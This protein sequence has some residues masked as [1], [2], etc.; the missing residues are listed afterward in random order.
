[1]FGLCQHT[2]IC[3]DIIDVRSGNCDATELLSRDIDEDGVV[4]SVQCDSINSSY[5]VDFDRYVVNKALAYCSEYVTKAKFTRRIHVNVNHSSLLDVDVINNLLALNKM[6]SIKKIQLVVELLEHT[7]PSWQTIQRAKFLQ[8]YGIK[9]AID[10]YGTGY[11]KKKYLFNF[12]NPDYVKIVYNKNLLALL[13]ETIHVLY[14][15]K[16]KRRN[17]IVEYIDSKSKSS[18]IKMLGF[19]YQQGFYFNKKPC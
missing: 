16:L 13:I 14:D 5:P 19:F 1:M 10:D 18:A 3:Q 11:N 7:M 4:V 6:L 12:R 2:F 9:I 15:F 17:I 8:G